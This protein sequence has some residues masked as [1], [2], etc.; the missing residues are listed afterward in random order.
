MKRYY[1]LH[2]LYECQDM[3]FAAKAANRT[4]PQ[5]SCKILSEIIRFIREIRS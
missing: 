1:E 2:E 5:R 3:S 4:H